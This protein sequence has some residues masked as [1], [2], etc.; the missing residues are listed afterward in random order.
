MRAF[1]LFCLCASGLLLVLP[2]CSVIGHNYISPHVIAFSP[3]YER[4]P[5]H[6][7]EITQVTFEGSP[8]QL[9]DIALEYRGHLLKLRSADVKQ[10]APFGRWSWVGSHGSAMVIYNGTK[11]LAATD[12]PRID[13]QEIGSFEFHNDGTVEIQINN[14]VLADRDGRRFRLP[15]KLDDARELLGPFTHKEI[16]YDTSDVFP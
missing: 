13:V 15:M 7:K 8:S 12:W 5:D 11:K 14:G 16:V 6:A 10:F 9:P 4:I 3:K 2:G 1:Q